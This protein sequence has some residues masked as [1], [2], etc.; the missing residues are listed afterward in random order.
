M[1]FGGIHDGLRCTLTGLLEKNLK[2]SL[3]FIVIIKFNPYICI[4]QK[5]IVMGDLDVCFFWILC[6]ALH[7]LYYKSK[8]FPKTIVG[9]II[10]FIM[11]VVL[12]PIIAVP[13]MWSLCFIFYEMP[14]PGPDD[15]F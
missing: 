13:V 15:P 4:G 6:L 11:A 3:N 2:K 12:S 1:Y 10:Y 5:L 14:C 8:H 7:L 9:T